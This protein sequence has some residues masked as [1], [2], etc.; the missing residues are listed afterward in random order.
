M[1]LADSAP[2]AADLVIGVPDSSTSAAIGYAERAGIPFEIGLVKNRYVGRTFLAPSPELRSTGV[3]MKLSAVRGVVG[4]QRVVMVDD[5]LVRGTTSRRIVQL[6]RDAG[7]VEVH[8]RIAC[9]PVTNPCFY[10]ID[11]STRDE[12]VAAHASIDEIRELV[13]ADS[14]AFLDEPTMMRAFAP[15]GAD[16]PACGHCNACFTGRYPVAVDDAPGKLDLERR[17]AGVR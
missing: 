9:P 4:G 16:R 13:G 17:L 8:V 2:A 7:A 3:R 14:L 5:S 10:G 1:L 15:A 12:L 6:L 11:T